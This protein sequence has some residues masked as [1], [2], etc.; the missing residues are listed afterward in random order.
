MGAK[1][2]PPLVVLVFVSLVLSILTLGCARPAAPSQEEISP[3]SSA[4]SQE[5]LRPPWSE[6]ISPGNESVN[7]WDWNGPPPII[8]PYT[9]PSKLDPNL[10]DLIQAEKRGELVDSR[11]R[12]IV[13]YLPGQSEAAAKAVATVGTVEIISRLFGIQA[14]VPISSLLALLEEKSITSIR[15]PEIVSSSAGN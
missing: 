5:K 15:R 12:V 9:G 14:L 1:K 13:R 10:W 2:K 11:V 4:P 7:P 8:Q 3:P 6:N